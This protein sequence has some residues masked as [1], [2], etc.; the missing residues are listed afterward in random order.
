MCARYCTKKRSVP[1]ECPCVSCTVGMLPLL[2]MLKVTR[3]S[4]AELCQ[5]NNCRIICSYVFSFLSC[6]N[7][8]KLN[9]KFATAGNMI[10]VSSVC[11]LLLTVQLSSDVSIFGN[12]Q[13]HSKEK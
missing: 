7:V 3:T 6:H 12:L 5:N 9:Q 13:L 10:Q 11:M 4:V 2:K 1:S 8:F